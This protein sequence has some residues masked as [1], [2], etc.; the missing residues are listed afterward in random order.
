[1]YSV[2]DQDGLY[3]LLKSFTTDESYRGPTKLPTVSYV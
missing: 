2:L 1:M 3:G